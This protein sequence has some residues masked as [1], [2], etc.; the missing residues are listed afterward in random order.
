MEACTKIESFEVPGNGHLAGF[1]RSPLGNDAANEVYANVK[2]LELRELQHA[3]VQSY[4]AIID[5]IEFL[6]RGIVC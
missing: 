4:D 5:E 1:L 2:D 3:E 6:E